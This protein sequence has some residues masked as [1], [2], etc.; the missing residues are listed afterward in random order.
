M[1]GPAKMD[2]R[3]FTATTRGTT[4]C[5]C[6]ASTPACG[7]AAW[8]V[9]GGQSENDKGGQGAAGGGG[10]SWQDGLQ[11]GCVGTAVVHGPMAL[12]RS[13]PLRLAKIALTQP[14]V[15]MPPASTFE[16]RPVDRW[17]VTSRRA[18][19][20]SAQCVRLPGSWE[21]RESSSS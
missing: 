13:Q 4:R 5:R 18:A 17:T 14:P 15:V 2:L 3:K 12:H 20:C 21:V 11:P 1:Q 9:D 10:N 7:V 6:A 19:G 8:A 16:A